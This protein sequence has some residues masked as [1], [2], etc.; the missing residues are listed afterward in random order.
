MEAGSTK[1]ALQSAEYTYKGTVKRRAS[2]AVEIGASARAA[3]YLS[4]GTG[5]LVH[6][7]VEPEGRLDLEEQG[8]KGLLLLGAWGS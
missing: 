3:R 4:R 8:L 2:S 1:S 5:V 6:V 7:L